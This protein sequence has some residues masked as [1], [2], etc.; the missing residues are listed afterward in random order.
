MGLT[1]KAAIKGV[2]AHH[3]NV[4]ELIPPFRKALATL[5]SMQKVRLRLVRYV[6]ENL[7]SNFLVIINIIE[8][9]RHSS[10]V[11]GLFITK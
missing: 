10:D 6:Y 8:T 5:A 7:S 9:T 4:W 11:C 2:L 3:I 1:V